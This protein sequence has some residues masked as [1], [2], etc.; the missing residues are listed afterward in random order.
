MVWYGL[1]FGLYH[2]DLLAA[3]DVPPLE[4][5]QF[6]Q[7]LHPSLHPLLQLV[8]RNGTGIHPSCHVGSSHHHDGNLSS[9]SWGIIVNQIF[10]LMGISFQTLC[11]LST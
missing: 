6:G 5:I 2:P 8:C 10:N 4:R 7:D 1:L 11:Y 9:L 3:A